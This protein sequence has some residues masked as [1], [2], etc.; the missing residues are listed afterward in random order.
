MGLDCRVATDSPFF[1]G[2][3]GQ[4]LIEGLPPDGF[5]TLLAYLDRQCAAPLQAPFFFYRDVRAF[6]CL[7]PGGGGSP[8]AP[9]LLLAYTILSRS[10]EEPD[11]FWLVPF[12]LA[13]LHVVTGQN[14]MSAPEAG[15]DLLASIRRTGTAP[16][17]LYDAVER[18]IVA[19][20]RTKYH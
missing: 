4:W 3:A 14:T 17:R 2:I 15:A 16:P 5:D 6:L 1:D 10:R 9:G 11:T 12:L 13:P 7:L 19:G 8:A 18:A 20:L